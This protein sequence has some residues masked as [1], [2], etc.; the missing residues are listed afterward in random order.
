LLGVG[1][2]REGVG[3]LILP[4]STLWRGVT[5]TSGKE[6]RG[7]Q[8]MGGKIFIGG[9]FVRKKF[10]SIWGE[11]LTYRGGRETILGML[12]GSFRD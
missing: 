1:A 5:F 3:N 9:N 6:K 4:Y 11:F 12:R 7:L 8:N 10:F 2:E